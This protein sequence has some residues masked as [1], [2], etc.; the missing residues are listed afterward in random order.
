MVWLGTVILLGALGVGV[1][2]GGVA[3]GPMMAMIAAQ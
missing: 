1:T 2:A 3:A